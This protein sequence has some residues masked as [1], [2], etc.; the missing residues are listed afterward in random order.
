VFKPIEEPSLEFPEA[1]ESIQP[2]PNVITLHSFSS[3]SGKRF[4]K[5]TVVTSMGTL[6]CSGRG[7]LNT[8][9]YADYDPLR[10]Q[11]E[12]GRCDVLRDVRD[13]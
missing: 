6:T 12:F 2:L 10:V 11:F 13:R 9:V 7:R 3:V 1:N 5:A 8:S 4:Q